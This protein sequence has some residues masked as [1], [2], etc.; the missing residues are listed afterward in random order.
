LEEPPSPE[1]E[2]GSQEPRQSRGN[3]KQIS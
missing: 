1:G 3:L 2:G